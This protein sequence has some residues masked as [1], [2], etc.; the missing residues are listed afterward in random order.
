MTVSRWLM[1]NSQQPKIGFM[2]KKWLFVEKSDF[3]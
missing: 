3:F 1:A 2:V